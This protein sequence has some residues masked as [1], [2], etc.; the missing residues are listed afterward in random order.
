MESDNFFHTFSKYPFEYKMIKGFSIVNCWLSLPQPRVT[1]KTQISE[2]PQKSAKSPSVPP[3]RVLVGPERNVWNLARRNSNS[4]KFSVEQ[5]GA[6]SNCLEEGLQY[7]SNLPL[8]V[9]QTPSTD[10]H[11]PSMGDVQANQIKKPQVKEVANSN[12]L[13]TILLSYYIQ[14]STN[15]LKKVWKKLSLSINVHFQ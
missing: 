10:A 11:F 5:Y 2:I 4:T 12:S 8:D 6:D 15:I 14:I 1:Q 9:R 7:G 3:Q 13:S